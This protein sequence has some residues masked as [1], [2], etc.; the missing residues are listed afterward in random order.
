MV[1]TFL[2]SGIK[3]TPQRVAVFEAL[4]S[5]CHASADE[6]ISKVQEKAPYISPATIYNTLDK[7]VQMG[8]I[9]RVATDGNKMFFDITPTPHVHLCADD[10]SF[11]ADAHIPELE[12][13]I[14]D[15][16]PRVQIPG[17]H[18]SKIQVNLVGRFEGNTQE[19]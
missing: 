1:T 4:E 15:Y 9:S 8:V 18:L 6:V 13:L 10:N 14:A 5:L 7:F 17:F 2:K 11:I 19:K 3:I 16:L 12:Q